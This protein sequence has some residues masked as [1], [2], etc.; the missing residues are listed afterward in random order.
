MHAPKARHYVSSRGA[1]STGVGLP[2]EIHS[3]LWWT[4]SEE[5]FKWFINSQMIN[6]WR[7]AESWVGW[8]RGSFLRS[9]KKVKAMQISI[10]CLMRD[11]GRGACSNIARLHYTDAGE[12]A[13][14]CLELDVG[15]NKRRLALKLL[16]F[17]VLFAPEECSDD[18][19]IS[20]FRLLQSMFALS[21]TT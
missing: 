4:N 1:S 10:T 3:L 18:L 20:I 19:Q 16:R 14:V 15:L 17:A 7:L 12:R 5:S 9:T 13:A 8:R 6:R 11:W 21:K 2:S